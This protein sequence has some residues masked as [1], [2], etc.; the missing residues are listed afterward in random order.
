MVEIVAW[1]LVLKTRSIRPVI[2]KMP[3]DY[4]TVCQMFF[5]LRDCPVE[6][7]TDMSDCKNTW[8]IVEYLVLSF[9][10]LQSMQS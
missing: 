3:F 8:L 10:N 5:Q 9:C 1:L 7:H 2:F 4:K 6:Y